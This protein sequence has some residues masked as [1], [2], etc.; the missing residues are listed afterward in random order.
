MI[1]TAM[2]GVLPEQPDPASFHHVLDVGCGAGDWVISVARAYPSISRL[3]G[4]DI[5]LKMIEYARAQA[6]KQGVADRVEFSVMDATHK[7]EFPEHVFSLVNLRFGSSYLRTWDW[8]N[9]LSEL[10]RVTNFGGIIRLTESNIA[11]SSP[12]HDQLN[13]LMMDALYASGHLFER[14]RDSMNNH[15]SGLLHQHG[16]V[17]NVQTRSYPIEFHPGLEQGQVFYEDALRAYRTFKPFLQKWGRL[18]EDYEQIYQ[19]MLKELKEP[20]TLV[21]WTLLTAWGKTPAQKA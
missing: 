17:G 14:D 11:Y 2:G 12:A 4:V 5:N 18:P 19:R 8:P 1:T 9:V 6:E 16:G 3:V 10:Q 21:T 13:L 20:D 7:L 15:L